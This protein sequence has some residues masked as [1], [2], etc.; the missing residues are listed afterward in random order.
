MI[1]SRST[2]RLMLFLCLFCTMAVADDVLPKKPP[3]E[4][5]PLSNFKPENFS[6]GVG[7][8][9]PQD[10]GNVGTIL[11]TIDAFSASGLILIDT[12]VDITHPNCVRAS[13]G[14][15]F[16][17]PVI[18]TT[19]QDFRKWAVSDNYSVYGTS[20]RGT[21]ELAEMERFETPMILL[22][23]SEKTGLESDHLTV[24]KEVL[25]LPNLGR[26]TSLNLAVAAGIF[27]YE[28]G[29]SFHS[30]QPGIRAGNQH[31]N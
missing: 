17:V 8:V 7:L 30:G 21:M 23:G 27:L 9:S 20:V 19:F 5:F 12:H 18:E 24:C 1:R 15:I 11:R 25:C 13:M 4:F 2:I 29:R 14:A 28:I 3:G 22:M 6:R 16:H 10:P 31:E 26:V